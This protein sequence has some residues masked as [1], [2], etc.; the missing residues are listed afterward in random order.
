MNTLCHYLVNVTQGESA[1]LILVSGPNEQLCCDMAVHYHANQPNQLVWSYG[2]AYDRSLGSNAGRFETKAVPIPDEELHA[3]CKLQLHIKVDTDKL[4]ENGSYRSSRLEP[5]NL[6]E[7][8]SC[9]STKLQVRPSTFVPL[10]QKNGTQCLDLEDVELTW[11][12]SSLIHCSNCQ[13][14]DIER[15][16]RTDY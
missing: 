3:M 10:I 5:R 15:I 14:T 6:Y 7:C 1:S 9:H 4:Q 12:S 2:G 16:F 8:P 13:S 11:D